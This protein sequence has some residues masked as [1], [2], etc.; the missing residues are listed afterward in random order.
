MNTTYIS[1]AQRCCRFDDEKRAGRFPGMDKC[2]D[3]AP[4]QASSE[5]LQAASNN[6]LSRDL[7]IPAGWPNLINYFDPEQKKVHLN[8]IDDTQRLTTHS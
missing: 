5:T 4:W 8:L 2:T 1:C 7:K 6:I 3:Q